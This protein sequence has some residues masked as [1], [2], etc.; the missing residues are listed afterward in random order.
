[1]DRTKPRINHTVQ[2]QLSFAAR[3]GYYL[4]KWVDSLGSHTRRLGRKD[5]I[6]KADAVVAAALLEAKLH[7]SPGAD[8]RPR[9]SIGSHCKGRYWTMRWRDDA[10]WH[11][12]NL[13]SSSQMTRE[14]ALEV[15]RKLELEIARTLRAAPRPGDDI[16][17][18][19]FVRRYLEQRKTAVGSATYV[20][21][22]W[23]GEYLIRFF[24]HDP[25]ITE[26]TRSDA[27]DWRT[28]LAKGET[29]VDNALHT[30]PPAEAT[31][32]KYCRAV[33]KMFNTAVD[34]GLIE[35]NPFAKLRGTPRRLNKSWEYITQEQLRAILDACPDQAW[36]CLFALARF[37][38]LRRGECLSLRWQDVDWAGNK[39]LVNAQ[40]EYVT[41]KHRPRVT[42]IETAKNPT[43][44]TAV[45]RDAFEAAQ[46]GATLVCPFTW[47]FFNHRKGA[48]IVAS[49]GVQS[50]AKIFHTLRKNWE[51]DL[52]ASYPQY[53][54][55][56]WAG[57]SI[58][59]SAMHYLRVPAELYAP[60]PPA[61]K[62]QTSEVPPTP[63]AA[64]VN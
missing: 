59:V 49:A 46:D 8:P 60:P 62:L 23:L 52:A 13:G 17:L 9:A 11:R 45:L 38:G 37:A 10:G 55:A 27:A 35:A 31:V 63:T 36:R 20:I 48:G 43:G 53:V 41:T 40:C 26:L 33:R 16:T 2:V 57:H 22:K 15:C 58:E 64:A 28:A 47:S 30:D 4:A 14:Q 6:S 25:P 18:S 54:V 44:L 51:M 21:D 24:D 5:K 32:C 3:S 39:L 34:E 7:K 12:R 19:G 42:P 29:H 1:M 61:E 56:E 50:Y